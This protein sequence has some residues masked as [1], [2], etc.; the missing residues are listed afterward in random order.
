MLSLMVPG[1][2]RAPRR[3]GRWSRPPR[4]GRRLASS[5][6]PE[7]GLRMDWLQSA[8]ESPVPA[9]S[10]VKL[11]GS[12]RAGCRWARRRCGRAAFPPVESK[13]GNRIRAISARSLSRRQLKISVRGRALQALRWPRAVPMRP[14]DCAPHPA[15]GR[16]AETPAGPATMCWQSPLQSRRLLYCNFYCYMLTGFLCSVIRPPP[17]SPAPGCAAGARRPA[18]SAPAVARHRAEFR[19]GLGATVQ[20]TP[21]RSSRPRSR[22]RE[23]TPPHRN[24]HIQRHGCLSDRPVGF[25][26]L[27]QRH[28]RSARRKIPAFSRAISLIVSPRYS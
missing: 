19:N 3:P 18:E 2:P 25:R 12:P 4:S 21:A 26:V 5:F 7:P 8:P 23:E 17:Q 11:P 6:W 20:L 1:S 27:R 24:A 13:S 22:D 15:A 10:P 28:Q 14:P 9:R 16:E